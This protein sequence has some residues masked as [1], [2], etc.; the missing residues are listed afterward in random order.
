MVGSARTGWQA[1]RETALVMKAPTG[2]LQN[3]SKDNTRLIKKYDVNI[4]HVQGQEIFAM[5]FAEPSMSI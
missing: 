4:V 2:V 1:A 5:G 3:V